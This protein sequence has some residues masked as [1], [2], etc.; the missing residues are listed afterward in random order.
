MSI[1]IAASLVTSL[2]ARMAA[3][4]ALAWLAA[5]ITAVSVAG[6][7]AASVL[8][9]RSARRP[10]HL[11]IAPRLSASRSSADVDVPHAA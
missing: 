11:A 6:L 8:F 1:P 2:A 10:Y 7:L 5:I 4:D 3:V 9:E